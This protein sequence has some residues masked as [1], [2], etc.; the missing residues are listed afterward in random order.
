MNKPE[1]NSFDLHLIK[2]TKDAG[3]QLDYSITAFAGSEQFISRVKKKDS[4]IPHPDL[5]KPIGELRT[6]L[7]QILHYENTDFVRIKGLK[8]GDDQSVTFIGAVM[9]QSGEFADVK[10]PKLK[11]DKTTYGYESLL[12][13]NLEFIKEEA[14]KYIFEEKQA[15]LEADL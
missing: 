12:I 13:I 11:Y 1:R 4:R 15:Q 3:V 14:Y 2:E 7:A 5:I 10:F 9:T 6:I 8:I